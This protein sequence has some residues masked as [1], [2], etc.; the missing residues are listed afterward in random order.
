[1]SFFETT[2]E[3]VVIPSE[4]GYV[5][6]NNLMKLLVNT[7]KAGNTSLGAPMLET[8]SSIQTAVVLN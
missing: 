5:E 1:M 6:L 2:V 4:P 8:T 3:E 7:F